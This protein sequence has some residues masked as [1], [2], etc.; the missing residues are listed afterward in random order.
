MSTSWL[1]LKIPP[2]F[3][4]LS[5]GCLHWLA[6][7]ISPSWAQPM[8]IWLS[9]GAVVFALSFGCMGVFGC[10]Q[11]KTTI[12]PWSPEET[13][14]LVTTGV[15][16][17]SRNPMYLA[18]MLLLFAW[19]IQPLHPLSLLALWGSAGYLVQFQIRPEERTLA[20]KFPQQFAEYS[21]NV[22]RWI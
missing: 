21:R 14:C 15:F 19:V 13:A 1:E 7:W 2:P 16:S 18:L 12:H 10:L 20:A 4:V 11:K 22:P 9:F 17:I 3:I 6:V 5:M 8:P